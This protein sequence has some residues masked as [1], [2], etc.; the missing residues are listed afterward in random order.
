MSRSSAKTAIESELA[1]LLEDQ[2][3]ANQAFAGVNFYAAQRSGE[4]RMPAVVVSCPNLSDACIEVGAYTGE[5]SVSVISSI[6]EN[7]APE[8][9][10]ESVDP[11]HNSRVTEVE[12]I[13]D[14]SAQVITILNAGTVLRVYGY[15]LSGTSRDIEGRA[16]SDTIALTVTFQPIK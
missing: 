14:E 15:W 10:E 16:F 7:G 13:L 11:L 2:L 8:V 5:V 3:K 9:S 1:A 4:K 12:S 6:D